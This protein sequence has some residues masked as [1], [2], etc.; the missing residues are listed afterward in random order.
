MTN[1]FILAGNRQFVLVLGWQ[2]LTSPHI[3]WQISTG[4]ALSLGKYIENVSISYTRHKLPP[5]THTFSYLLSKPRCLVLFGLL[6][7]A[8]HAYPGINS[9]KQLHSRPAGLEL[10]DQEVFLMLANFHSPA[11]QT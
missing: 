10:K 7:E 2:E 1:I 4:F 9:N 8:L 6:E 5:H 11:L 3:H